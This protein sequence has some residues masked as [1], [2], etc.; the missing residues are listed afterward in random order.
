MALTADR[1][2]PFRDSEL[3]PVP[4][5]ASTTIYAGSLVVSNANGYAAPGSA[6]AGLVALGRAEEQVI[7]GGANGAKTVAVRRNKAFKFANSGTDAVVQADLGRSCYIEDDQTV[8]HTATS[9]SV[10]GTV[11]QLDTDGV[12]V[13]I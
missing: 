7:N 2:T 12:W 13:K 6:I 1:N 11:L 8:C 4:V 10:A 3:F 9:K 5:A